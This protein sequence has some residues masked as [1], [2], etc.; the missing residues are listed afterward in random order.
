MQTQ[1]PIPND[2]CGNP[3]ET[4]WYV[5]HSSRPENPFY[6]SDS[7]SH[8]TIRDNGQIEEYS[9][10]EDVIYPASEF[11]SHAKTLYPVNPLIFSQ[12]L[13]R[14]ITEKSKLIRFI[15]GKQYGLLYQ[16][17]PLGSRYQHV[18][19]PEIPE[20]ALELDNETGLVSGMGGNL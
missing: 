10:R 20:D 4:G 3:L 17:G 1:T 15:Q 6:G 19:T 9:L 5:S 2:A 12:R 16:G 11:A 7:I 8:I 14:E 18:K 13:A